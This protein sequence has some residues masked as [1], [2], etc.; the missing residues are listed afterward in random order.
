MKKIDHYHV[1]NPFSP[2]HILNKRLED[3]RVPNLG[4]TNKDALLIETL[5]FQ[6]GVWHF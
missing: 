4:L 6:M 1:A 5:S 2:I 3:T